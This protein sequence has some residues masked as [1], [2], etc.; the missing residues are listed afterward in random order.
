M[1]LDTYRKE[2]EKFSNP[3][4]VGGKI[5]DQL[6]PELIDD[7]PDGW[8][9]KRFNP[10]F[11]IKPNSHLFLLEGN[12]FVGRKFTVVKD[13]TCL[14][15]LYF[16]DTSDHELRMLFKWFVVE[17]R[18]LYDDFRYFLKKLRLGSFRFSME[19]FTTMFAMPTYNELKDLVDRIDRKK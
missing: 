17:V 10:R 6:R 1:L 7:Y 16:I 12:R 8:F 15:H 13:Y 11:R 2:L 5:S 14:N 18:Y 9:W 19:E 4:F 3:V